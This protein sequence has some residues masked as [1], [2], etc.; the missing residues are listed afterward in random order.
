MRYWNVPAGGFGAK[1]AAA[2]TVANATVD[3]DSLIFKA[4]GTVFLVVLQRTSSGCRYNAVARSSVD[5]RRTSA[6]NYTA[7]GG[8]ARRR[9]PTVTR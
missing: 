6:A 9:W 5:S 3:G 7:I 1:Q 4:S 8:D 2:F